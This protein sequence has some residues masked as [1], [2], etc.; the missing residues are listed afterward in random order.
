MCRSEQLLALFVWSCQAAPE[1]LFGLLTGML[2]SPTSQDPEL[3]LL[4]FPGSPEKKKAS[5]SS[6]LAI[7]QYIFQ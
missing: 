7:P 1:F 4:N 3:S 2:G 5:L 6:D